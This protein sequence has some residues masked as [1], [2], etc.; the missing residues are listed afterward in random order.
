MRLMD[1]AAFPTKKILIIDKNKKQDN[2]RTWCFWER[3]NGYFES[4]VYKSWNDLI[5]KD[6]SDSLSLNMNGYVYKMIRGIDFYEYCFRCIEEHNN[7]DFIVEEIMDVI[8]SNGLVSITTSAA[9]L[10]FSADFVFSSIFKKPKLSGK[11][12]YLLQHFK[13]W[14]INTKTN[15]FNPRQAL[16][17]DFG[18]D[19]KN[20][21]VAFAYVLPVSATKALVEYTV[22]SDVVFSADIYDQE[23]RNYIH[24]ALGIEDYVVEHSEFGVIPMTNHRF[25]SFQ[26]GIFN[27]GTAGGQT[28]ASTGYT[29]QF[30]Q[31]QATYLAAKIISG[32][33]MKDINISNPSRFHL[34]DSIMLR[35]LA[36]KKMKGSNIFIRLF[37]RVPASLVFKFLDNETSFAEEWKILRAMPTR[38]FLPAAIR[39]LV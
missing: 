30:I 20:C 32:R 22:F 33:K 21:P 25:A 36:K 19:Q 17:M 13:G 39:E 31:K 2:D 15:S 16:L 11:A 35:V 29:F 4:I 38:V 6:G 7:I 34:Y 14:M 8:N 37:E 3:E 5:V 12:H 27:I 10:E 26:N 1:D 9:K 18:V 23:L 24:N 28:K